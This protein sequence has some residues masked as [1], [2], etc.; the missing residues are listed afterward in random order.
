MLVSTSARS[1]NSRTESSLDIYSRENSHSWAS[2]T[3]CEKTVVNLDDWLSVPASSRWSLS[4]FC[5]DTNFTPAAVWQVWQIVEFSFLLSRFQWGRQCLGF[6]RSDI[7]RLLLWFPQYS[8]PVAQAQRWYIRSICGL[9]QVLLHFD[10]VS[11][12]L[13]SASYKRSFHHSWVGPVI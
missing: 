1:R 12:L 3:R 13:L 2:V 11:D 5:F 6:T 7:E 9:H 8:P 10:Q 4:T